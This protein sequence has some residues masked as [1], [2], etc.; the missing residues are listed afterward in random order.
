M[1]GFATAN[2]GSALLIRGSHFAADHCAAGDECSI[3]LEHIECIGFLIMYFDLPRTSA[4][5]NLNIEVR[6]CYESATLRNLVVT[7][8]G[9]VSSNGSCENSHSQQRCECEHQPRLHQVHQNNRYAA[10]R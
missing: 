6:C 1:M 7:H 5:Q 10:M 2:V 9:Y 8:V 4:R 3:T